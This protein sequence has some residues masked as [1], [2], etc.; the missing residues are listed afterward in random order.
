VK[1]D[2]EGFVAAQERKRQVLGQEV[3]FFIPTATTWPAGVKDEEGVPLDPTTQPLSSGV[4]SASAV[5]SLVNRPV[6]G[7]ARGIQPHSEETAAGLAERTSVI[8]IISKT[9]YDALGLAAAAEAEV[10]E[11][12]YAVRD[13]LPDQMG[14]GPPQRML[15]FLEKR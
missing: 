6:A 2:V 11:S 9:A 7:G 15:I 1:P 10:F 4:A 8:A 5:V 12:L 3:T 14:P 13:K